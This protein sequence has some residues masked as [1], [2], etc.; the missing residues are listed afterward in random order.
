M[1]SEFPHIRI[2]HDSSLNKYIDEVQLGVLLWQMVEMGPTSRRCARVKFCHNQY[3]IPPR[4]APK[5]CTRRICW[6]DPGGRF[7]V[8][9]CGS[10]L[11][12]AFL[13]LYS[14]LSWYL[15]CLRPCKWWRWAPLVGDVPGSSFATT[16]MV[17][18]QEMH[19][20]AE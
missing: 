20:I 2:W 15:R 14:L 13:Y 9:Y 7:L 4:N 10:P 8:R 19:P 1:H 18:R 6:V 17:S 16:N 5:A 12:L 11:L 3:G